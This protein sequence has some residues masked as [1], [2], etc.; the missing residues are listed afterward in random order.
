LNELWFDRAEAAGRI[1]DNRKERNQRGDHHLWGESEAK[2]NQEKRRQRHFRQNLSGNEKW[3][4]HFAYP[5]R[6]GDA[7]RDNET[8]HGGNSEAAGYCK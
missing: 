5:T 2:P 7:D 3:I 6:I 1:D 4:R 8:E